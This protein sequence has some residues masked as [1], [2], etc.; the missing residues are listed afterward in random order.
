LVRSSP[1]PQQPAAG[2]FRDLFAGVG[3]P[4]GTRD[5]L[6]QRGQRQQAGRAT[7]EA[8]GGKGLSRHEEAGLSIHVS[9]Y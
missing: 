3:A 7:S 5:I 6:A 2:G 9:F 1:L 8:A 4:P